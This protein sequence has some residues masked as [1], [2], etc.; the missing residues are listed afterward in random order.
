MGGGGLIR[1][2]GGVGIIRR[3]IVLEAMSSGA[4]ILGRGSSCTDTIY[5]GCGPRRSARCQVSEMKFYG[6]VTPALFCHG[7]AEKNNS[8]PWQP[9]NLQKI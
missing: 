6:N 7:L 5:S 2:G 1:G 9:R 3:A 8:N 4:I